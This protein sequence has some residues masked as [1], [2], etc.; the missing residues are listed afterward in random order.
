MGVSLSGISTLDTRKIY[1]RYLNCVQ[2]CA[3]HLNVTQAQD[4]TTLQQ[5]DVFDMIE[6]IRENDDC[7]NVRRV[8]LDNLDNYIKI[9]TVPIVLSDRS[10]LCVNW[11]LVHSQRDLEWTIGKSQVKR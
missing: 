4:A 2:L 6:C 1:T 7:P 3:S 8:D 11:F 5:L 10:H 9:H